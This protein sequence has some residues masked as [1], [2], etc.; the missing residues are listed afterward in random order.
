MTRSGAAFLASL[1]DERCVFVDGQRVQDVGAHPALA[2]AAASI[3][4]L[5]D[6]A[7][8]PSDQEDMTFDRDGRP[9]NACFLVPRSRDDLAARRRAHKR[10]ADSSFG[11]LGRSPDH[12]AS[13]LTGFAAAAPFF[14]DFA[15]NVTRFH[16]RAA[17]E[18]L[19]VAYAIVHPTIDRSRPAH[20][21]AEPHLYA[22]VVEERD[23]GIVVRGAQMLATAGVFAD[24]IFVS[25]ILPLK[26]GD[27][28]YALS[29][30]VPTATRGVKLYARRPYA[31]A[32]TSVFDYPLS[33]RFD[34][35]DSLVVLDDV[36]VPWE[37]VF[38][39]RDLERTFGQFSPR[40]PAHVLSNTQAQIRFWSKL[41]FLVG[42]VNQAMTLSGQAT[43]P[44]VQVQLGDLAARAALVEGLVLAAEAHAVVDEWGV[45]RPNPRFVYAN[46]T[47]QSSLYPDMIQL[48]RELLSGS[49]LEL[50][51][52]VE[53]LRRPETLADMQRYVR[54]PAAEGV[55]R[56]KVLKLLWDLVGSEFAGRHMQYEM[57]YAGQPAVVKMKA[58]AAYD[59]AAAEQLVRACLE[60]YGVE[61]DGVR[62]AAG[63]GAVE[64]KARH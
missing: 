42:L 5:Y 8:Q 51:S 40:L 34:E 11:L 19:Y 23:D 39:Y 47:L 33:S 3:A 62:T 38:V 25:V 30:V 49:L 63:S 1:R 10:W 61:A 15:D 7:H 55:E 26:P 56:I 44:E 12:V 28:D 17:L 53:E 48:V 4:A 52:S 46:Q 37:Q 45:L 29:F 21:Q 64:A 41:Q 60:S 58:N 35:T 54:W 14:G 22:S 27:E 50:P 9:V 43:R 20:Q 59:W 24:V 16:A 32:A 2:A 36:F 18:D 6:L 31:S 13:L 57:F